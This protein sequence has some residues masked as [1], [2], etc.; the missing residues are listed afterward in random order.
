MIASHFMGLPQ[1]FIARQLCLS[2]EDENY[3]MEVSQNE[4]VL[5]RDKGEEINK[6]IEPLY[7][8]VDCLD[9]RI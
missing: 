9:E 7:M 4:M 8:I 3:A 2:A 1:K 5:Q 6:K